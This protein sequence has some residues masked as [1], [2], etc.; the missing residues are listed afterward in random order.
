MHGKQAGSAVHVLA[1]VAPTDPVNRTALALGLVASAR[2]AGCGPVAFIDADRQGD[3]TRMVSE[4]PAEGVTLLA[5]AP[6]QVPAHLERLRQQGFAVVAV[7]APASPL[8]EMEAALARA[9]LAVIPVRPDEDGLRSVATTVDLVDECGKPFVFVINGAAPGEEIDPTVAM[10]LVQYGPL[11]PIVVPHRA[12]VAGAP[13]DGPN[14]PGGEDAEGTMSRLWTYIAGRLK[15]VAEPEVRGATVA[16]LP[17]ERREFPRWELAWSATL[18]SGSERRECT[19][20]NISGGGMALQMAQ[21]PEEGQSVTIEAPVLGRLAAVVVRVS[22]DRVGLR[23]LLDTAEKWRLAE[24]L[25][26]FAQGKQEVTAHGA[27]EAPSPLPS[28]ADAVPP[29]GL[30]AEPPD[31]AGVEMMIEHAAAG[32]P[33]EAEPSRFHPLA[34]LFPTM[35]ADELAELTA[36]IKAHGLREPIVVMPEPDGRILDG[37]HR[38]LAC[39]RAGVAPHF[40]TFDGAD[41]AAYVIS[42]NLRRRHLKESQR[43]MIAARLANLDE[44]RPPTTAQDYA[45]S[46]G[47]AAAMLGVSRRSVQSAK[48]V[49]DRGAPELIEAV[50]QGRISVN[51]AAQVAKKPRREQGALAK[52]GARRMREAVKEAPTRLSQAGGPSHE[53]GTPAVDPDTQLRSD[54]P[55]DPATR[56]TQWLALKVP[57]W[58]LAALSLTPEEAVEA[59]PLQERADISQK[60]AT[61]MEWLSRVAERLRQAERAEAERPS[62]GA[63]ASGPD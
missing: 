50:E 20:A 2:R 21:P 25:G 16:A 36:D 44:G 55:G 37:R 61:I 19:V 31:A 8:R 9:S 59:V 28:S 30:P 10:A 27:P 32:P 45:V 40:R 51:I 29:S 4:R 47:Q 48:V 35:G 14:G 56:R 3:P 42:A 49:R 7:D 43:A 33:V 18:V 15:K 46:Q 60:L 52:A 39:E 1:F 26:G 5:S 6:G 13:S 12:E 57:L 58:Q 11:S 17:Q 38:Y 63:A 34:L 54:A 24:R 23:F 41:A 22:N 53:G 62:D